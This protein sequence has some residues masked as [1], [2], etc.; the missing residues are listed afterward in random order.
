MFLFTGQFLYVS[1]LKVILTKKGGRIMTWKT[2]NIHLIK[3]SIF[4]NDRDSAP[5]FKR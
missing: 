2:V 3:G 5:Y 4:A 1:L